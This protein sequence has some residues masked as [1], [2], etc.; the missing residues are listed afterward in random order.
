M[1][2][3]QLKY[4]VAAARYE[5]VN[6]AAKATA[7]S[8]SVI[9]HAIKQLEEE[10]GCQLFSRDRKR[11]RLTAQGV[12]FFELSERLLSQADGMRREL[13]TTTIE[14]SGHYRIA[15][16]HFLAAE[17]VGPAWTELQNRYTTVTGEISAQPSWTVVESVLSGK[18]DFGV[19]FSPAQHPRLETEEIFRGTAK[20][21]VRKNHPVLSSSS[22][23]RYKLLKNHP[24]TMHMASERIRTERPHPA[25]K[26]AGLDVPVTFSFDSDYVALEHL[27]HSDNWAMMIDFIAKRFAKDLQTIPFPA[28][29][30]A[31]YTVQILWHKSRRT[32]PAMREVF[33]MIRERASTLR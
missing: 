22:R 23:G 15:A 13:G 11:I 6:R 20:L 9:S 32:D 16:S 28:E 29:E 18:A 30:D 5:H 24:A 31:V 27:K 8:A 10:Y 1:T 25:L 19:A 14:L 33:R 17:L 12:R 26:T 21:V 4:F 7:I 3:D 2:L